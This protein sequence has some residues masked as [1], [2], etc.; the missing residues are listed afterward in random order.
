MLILAVRSLVM[1]LSAAGRRRMRKERKRSRE[2]SRSERKSKATIV[3]VIPR[4]GSGY[5]LE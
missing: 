5:W 2:S 1:K 3:V 4:L